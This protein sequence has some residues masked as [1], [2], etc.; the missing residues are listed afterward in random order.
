MDKKIV[1]QGHYDRKASRMASTE[2]INP[3]LLKSSADKTLRL[4]HVHF[5]Q[6]VNK[7]MQDKISGTILDY[8]CGPGIRTL[9]FIND[10][11]QL[12]GIDVSDKSLK[13]AR[14]MA[15][16]NN[17]KATY[18]NMDCEQ[19]SFSDNTFDLILD[20]GTF[21]SLDMQKALPEIIRILKN[22]GTLIAIETLGHNPLFNLNRYFNVI[23]QKR[24]RWAAEH[25][26][27]IQDWEQIRKYFNEFDLHYFGLLTPFCA[28]MLKIAPEKIVKKIISLFERIDEYLLKYKIFKRFSFKTVGILSKPIKI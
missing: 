9:K 28:I 13:I 2:D 20:Y 4:A 8:G 21:S 14:S 23:F 19:T 25:I 11:W 10:Q 12:T 5:D 18:L 3:E 17:I 15:E 16:R 24:T 7:V 6:A 26:M 22:D 27:K 1:E